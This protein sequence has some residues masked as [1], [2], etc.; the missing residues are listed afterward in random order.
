[1]IVAVILSLPLG[2]IAQSG[3]ESNFRSDLETEMLGMFETIVLLEQNNFFTVEGSEGEMISSDVLKNQFANNDF[4][5]INSDIAST[6]GSDL[7]SAVDEFDGL[8][9]ELDV[10]E[11]EINNVLVVLYTT[12]ELEGNLANALSSQINTLGIDFDAIPDAAR[13]R[14]TALTE[15][16]AKSDVVNM[17]ETLYTAAVENGNPL[18]RETTATTTTAPTTTTAD[19]STIRSFL[20]VTLLLIPFLN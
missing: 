20:S 1:M 8:M 18:T 11:A 15:L 7:S 4:S 3:D 5:Y 13:T 6:I 19:S 16:Q 12:A 9:E 2:L 14:L 10:T 17:K